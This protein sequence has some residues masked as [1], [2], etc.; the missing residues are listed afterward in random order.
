MKHPLWRSV[1]APQEIKQSFHLTSNS[2][3]SEF[4]YWKELVHE[5]SLQYSH[6]GTGGENEINFHLRV[7]G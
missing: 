6:R 3:S 5:C 4:L 2:V 1:A 7:N